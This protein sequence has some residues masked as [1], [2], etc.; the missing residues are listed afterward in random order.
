[1][2][3]AL[4]LARFNGPQGLA[5]DGNGNLF[6]A[7]TSNHRIRKI[8]TDGRVGTFAGAASGY[9]EGKGDLA[10]FRS[11]VGLAI[12]AQGRVYVGDTS[13]MVIRRAQ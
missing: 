5:F 12:D 8:G 3:E 11:P 6:V 2:D 4:A 13:N 9:T 7:D 1:R 10:Q